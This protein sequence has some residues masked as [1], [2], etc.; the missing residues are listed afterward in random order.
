MTTE[1][2]IRYKIARNDFK[3][4]VESAFKYMI[5]VEVM[6][7]SSVLNKGNIW[8]LTLVALLVTAVL[9]VGF[10]LLNRRFKKIN[11]EPYVSAEVF[12]DENEIKVDTRQSTCGG[13]RENKPRPFGE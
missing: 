2:D 6:K 4:G 9:S 1:D 12:A 10:W 7:N 8:W 11:D 13:F 5:D 3:K